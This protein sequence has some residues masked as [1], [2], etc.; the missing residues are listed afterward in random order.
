MPAG[1]GNDRDFP[2]DVRSTEV[3]ADALDRGAHPGSAADVE[4]ARDL[5]LVALLQAAGPELGP[6]PD[7]RARAR[8]AVFAR[9]AAADDPSDRVD[10]PGTAPRADGGRPAATALLDATDAATA[11]GP[12]PE[13]PAPDRP[14]DELSAR[15]S[16]GP[17][18]SRHAMPQGSASRPPVGGRIVMVAAAAV[19]GTAV[20]G[21]AGV[22]A[23]RNALPGDGLYPVKRVAESAQLAMTFDD[24]ERGRRHLDLAS[25]RIGE[26][27]Q[28]LADDPGG[29]EPEVFQSALRDFDDEAGEGSRLLLAS[30]EQQAQAEWQAWAAD[31]AGRLAT[32]RGD[33]PGP[34]AGDADGSLERLGQLAGPE[35]LGGPEGCAA[36]SPLCPGAPAD[37][38][39]PGVPAAADPAAGPTVPSQAGR[40]PSG[41]PAAPP[42]GS[43]GPAPAGPAPQG[44]EQP[45]LLPGL[46]PEDP[47]GGVLGGSD[48]QG[49]PPAERPGPSGEDDGGSDERDGSGG[50]GLPPVEVPPLLP[51]LPGVSLGG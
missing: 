30:Q 48:Q 3:F 9:L 39:P 35:V 28:L 6:R 4:L 23:S 17:R 16:R 45:G 22:L 36:G 12:D 33:L 18:G 43:G 51:G 13:P 21:G 29:V 20:L 50:G 42:S 46:L 34:A 2:G 38:T 25:T 37:A 15:R 10:V 7:E 41:A 5:E 11:T 40:A 27:E 24:V 44:G 32:L 8:A 1:Q 49:P 14:V 47:L 26:V 31:Q 19:L